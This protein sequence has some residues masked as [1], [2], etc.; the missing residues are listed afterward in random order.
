MG[1]V[2]GAGSEAA[3]QIAKEEESY[4]FMKRRTE[5]QYT[6]RALETIQKFV[7]CL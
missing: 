7:K 5:P 2:V 4:D 6:N 1:Y 3:W